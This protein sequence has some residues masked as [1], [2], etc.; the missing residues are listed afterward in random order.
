[1]TKD[2]AINIFGSAAKTAVAVGVS[3]SAVSQ[4]PTILTN[5]IELKVFGAAVRS[6]RWPC[7]EYAALVD[8]E[9]LRDAA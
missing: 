8:S 2:Q 9:A 6:G 4:W 3:P 5:D 7:H 1:M